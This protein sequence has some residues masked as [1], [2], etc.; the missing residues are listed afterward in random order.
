MSSR[1]GELARIREEL[2]LRPGMW[3]VRFRDLLGLTDDQTRDL[4]LRS[5]ESGELD[6]R[7][8][9]HRRLGAQEIRAIDF[10]ALAADEEGENEDLQEALVYLSQDAPLWDDYAVS[11]W[12]G[13]GARSC[14]RCHGWFDEAVF[15]EKLPSPWFGGA[16]RFCPDCASVVGARN[17][18][19][20]SLILPRIFAEHPPD[21]Q[22]DPDQ[23]SEAVAEALIAAHLADPDEEWLLY[24]TERGF[25]LDIRLDQSQTYPELRRQGDGWVLGAVEAAALR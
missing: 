23:W 20:A 13:G 7:D 8:G 18:E 19:R 21:A 22:T 6:L 5:V 10:D 9:S 25:A 15:G 14:G 11:D 1:G 16:E 24:E 3:C 12:P 17:R 4:L 2:T